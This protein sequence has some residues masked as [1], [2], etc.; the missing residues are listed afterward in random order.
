MGGVLQVLGAVD[1]LAV[2]VCIGVATVALCTN[3]AGQKI[4][5]LAAV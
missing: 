4:E 3:P 5:N 2:S 1:L